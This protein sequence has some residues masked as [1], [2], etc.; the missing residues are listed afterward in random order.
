MLSYE[1]KDFHLGD[2]L[3]IT[4]ERLVSPRHMDGVYE[5]L[6]FMTRDNLFTHQLPRACSECKP[7]LLR[8]HPDLAGIEVPELDKDSWKP[9]LEQQ[10]AIYGEFL[11]VEQ[12]PMDD[13]SQRNPLEELIEMMPDKK[14][15]VVE[16]E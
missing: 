8:Q 12:I 7:Y 11:A 5:I 15:I 6:N 4:T 3:S 14:V 16:L 13:H 2:I 10:V 1:T 9:W